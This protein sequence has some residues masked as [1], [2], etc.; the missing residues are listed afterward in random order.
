MAERPAGLL[1]V[2][3]IGRPHG[4]HGQVYVNLVTDRAERVAAGARLWVDDRWH[5]VVRSKPQQRRFLVVLDGIDTRDEA[6]RFTGRPIYAEPIDDPDALWVHELV[7]AAV[8]TPDG[9]HHGTCVA[10]VANPASDLIE[11]DDGTLIPT[12]FVTTFEGGV[13]T[14][15]VPDGL[16]DDAPDVATPFD[17]PCTDDSAD[18]DRGT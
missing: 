14:V 5:T 11:L 3:T 9:T 18:T 15:D 1:E 10:I 6:A 4:V 17:V 7:G 12:V 13:V 2:G 16:L 8:V